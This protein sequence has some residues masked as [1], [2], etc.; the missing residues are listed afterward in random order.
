LTFCI[1]TSS[2]ICLPSLAWLRR[3]RR[4]KSKNQKEEEKGTRPLSIYPHSTHS[5]DNT[6]DDENNNNNNNN[7]NNS[8]DR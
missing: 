5:F 6:N 4:K 7:N 3:Q 2:A 1:F 8:N